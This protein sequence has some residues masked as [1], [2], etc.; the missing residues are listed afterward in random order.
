MPINGTIVTGIHRQ[1]E[2]KCGLGDFLSRA[3][4][5]ES[6]RSSFDP[7]RTA[8]FTRRMALGRLGSRVSVYNA[9]V[10]SELARSLQVVLG[11]KFHSQILPFHTFAACRLHV[12]GCKA[13]M[14]LRALDIMNSEVKASGPY[15]TVDLRC[16]HKLSQASRGFPKK[17][18]LGVI[19]NVSL[20][21]KQMGGPLEEEVYVPEYQFVE[22]EE[23]ED[24]SEASLA[25][26]P[27]ELQPVFIDDNLPQG[28]SDH[29]IRE[30]DS[31]YDA[32]DCFNA[33]DFDP[34]QGWMEFWPSADESAE[35]SNAFGL[36]ES[37][38]LQP[39]E[40]DDK[41]SDTSV[42]D[43][44]STTHNEP[45]TGATADT[46]Q[47]FDQVDS[48]ESRRNPSTGDEPSVHSP[49]LAPG[50]LIYSLT[51]SASASRNSDTAFLAMSARYAFLTSIDEYKGF[52]AYKH[53]SP[54]SRWLLVQEFSEIHDF[55]PEWMALK[56]IQA[57][58]WWWKNG[59]ENTSLSFYSLKENR[60]S[61]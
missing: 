34:A 30:F 29:A 51:T 3:C 33:E 44:S 24:T 11:R 22:E 43:R 50:L 19:R 26:L 9:N 10:P 53:R 42:P 25:P 16:Y 56:K 49:E 54:G 32:A 14:A 52:T 58:H 7:L 21:V 2:T 35:P 31:D 36:G 23:E 61:D 41:T 45:D 5:F 46:I 27:P 13:D 39:N 55:S 57:K 40:P 28:D 37:S 12:T 18:G 38:V 47:Y 6:T 59:W 60:R 48:S 1:H 8:G 20:V 4:E 17:V 15:D